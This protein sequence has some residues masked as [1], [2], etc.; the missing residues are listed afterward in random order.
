MILISEIKLAENIVNSFNNKNLDLTY[1]YV[2]E[3]I[4][5]R[6]RS[7]HFLLE[8]LYEDGS[9]SFDNT[10]IFTRMFNILYKLSDN[11]F[12]EMSSKWIISSWQTAY[13][14]IKTPDEKIKA[15]IA[16]YNSMSYAFLNRKIFSLNSHISNFE[17]ETEYYYSCYLSSRCIDRTGPNPSLLCVLLYVSQELIKNYSHTVNDYFNP[18]KA[19]IVLG[20]ICE[21][22]TKHNLKDYKAIS[23]LMINTYNALINE[24]SQHYDA[25][26]HYSDPL[27]E[28][29]YM[30]ENAYEE[31][32]WDNENKKIVQ[33]ISE[34]SYKLLHDREEYEF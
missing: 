20:K 19:H 30:T 33:D 8:K 27:I 23:Y 6:G 24:Y 3:F 13:K 25:E 2:K 11:H 16:L 32:S 21:Y 9:L 4:N 26:Y 22:L 17:N 1:S 29:D 15:F 14:K 28:L 7:M 34:F 31:C 18:I 12:C 5:K 10:L